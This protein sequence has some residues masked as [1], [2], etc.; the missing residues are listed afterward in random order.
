MLLFEDITY[1][2]HMRFNA[3]DGVSNYLT[4]QV[5]DLSFIFI[6]SLSTFL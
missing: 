5:F 6:Y 1:G 2:F 3:T 4:I